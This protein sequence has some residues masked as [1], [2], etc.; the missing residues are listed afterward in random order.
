MRPVWKTL[1]LAQHPD[2]V[3]W[4]TDRGDRAFLAAHRDEV[5]TVRERFGD[6]HGS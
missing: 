2:P 1:F 5:E 3:T 4:L 6:P